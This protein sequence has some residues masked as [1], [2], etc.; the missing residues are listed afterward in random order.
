MR[1]PA[2][3]LAA[4]AALALAL[5]PALAEARPGGGRSMGSRGSQTYSAPPS[6]NTAPNQARPVERSMTSP[7]APTT[8]ARPGAAAGAAAPAAQGGFFSRNPLMAGL[9]GGLL[10]AGLFGLLG[11][12]GLFGGLSGL[13]GMFGLLLQIA[14]IGGLGY[15]VWRLVRGRFGQ[16]PAGAGGQ[17]AL[18]GVARSTAA[19]MGAMPREM[20]RE[21]RGPAAARGSVAAGATAARQQIAISA[22]DFDGFQRIL[23]EVNA[24][25]TAADTATLRR[26]ATP[27]MAGYLTADLAELEGRGLRNETSAVTLE[28]GDLAEA[29][30]EAGRDFATVAMRFSLID[31]T[32]RV[33]DGAVTEGD[34][35]RR[36]E[37][38]ELWTFLRMPG[39]SWL[40]S[41]VQQA[42]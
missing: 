25:W 9:A 6:T 14:L 22:E 8:A 3:M 21:A 31:V 27:E 4:T 23:T 26:L 12:S 16:Q 33:A 39:S 13:A 41:A 36:T 17:P 7:A 10:G 42:G 34:P 2:F 5:A 38:T 20:Q 30:Q 32:R 11:G 1:R 37:A 19:P 18:A 29:W 15:L 40:L 28:Q 35:A 24:A